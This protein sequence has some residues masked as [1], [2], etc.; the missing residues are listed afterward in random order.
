MKFNAIKPNT[1]TKFGA[2]RRLAGARLFRLGAGAVLL[3]TAAGSQ[4]V[5][6][7]TLRLQ[8]VQGPAG[9]V[10]SEVL[11]QVD[12]SGVKPAGILRI[13]RLDIPAVNQSFVNLVLRCPSMALSNHRISCSAGKL[14]V[15]S[16]W[17][18]DAAIP[19]SFDYRSIE[20]TL[21]LQLPRLVSTYNSENGELASEGLTLALQ[22]NLQQQEQR[23]NFQGELAAEAGQAYADPV[24]LDLT[25]MPIQVQF[26][27]NAEADS[28]RIEL[29][30]FKLQQPGVLAANGTL[31]W[32][33]NA[34]ETA[35]LEIERAQLP[36]AFS[37]YAQPFLIGT[38]FD[39]LTTEGV[40]RANIRRDKQGWSAIGIHG[41]GL[42]LK[43]G[44]DRLTIRG[45]ALD[46]DWQRDIALANAA[47]STLSWQDA[48][49]YKI[50]LGATHW[51]WQMAADDWA[52]TQAVSVPVFDG[53]LEI[54]SA[55]AN[56]L[57]S[58]NPQVDFNA[59]LTPVRLAKLSRAL[60]WPEFR[61]QVS[62]TLP[63]LQYRQGE[64]T[65]AGG[66][67]AK[68]FDGEI[69]LSDLSIANP[70]GARPRLKANATARNLDLEA[71]SSAFAFGRIT[72]RLDADVTGLRMLGWQ[73]V[74][75]KAWLRTPENDRSKH[76]ISQGA[77]DDLASL[78]GGG[79]AGLV[80]R[81]L[82][83]LF[84][85]FAYDRI[86]LGCAMNQGICL[87]RGLGPADNGGYVIVRGR[88]LPRIDV[89]GY[90]RFVSWSALLEQ[91]QSISK[92]P[93]PVINPDK[94]PAR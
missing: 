37:A 40:L 59:R 32:A 49:L 61:G 34:I 46:V 47:V 60:G 52:L 68:A 75:F 2:L 91:L 85:D 21:R 27:G 42:E 74:A 43:D 23:W 14:S 24:F 36:A 84:D 57:V 87:M 94:P 12:I 93:G 48:T 30:Q 28:G 55:A 78:G 90:N 44:K 76:R 3:L 10:A 6:S 1:H 38:A 66:L 18:T 71:M 56:G 26:A 50:E 15:K 79:G 13:A 25:K 92:S 45:G 7:L 11:L 70:L 19:I 62:G 73:P 51:N 4:A 69:E 67:Q 65:L 54:D 80:S 33:Q 16:P 64:L 88:W 77:I 89:V 83:G 8:Q 81:G 20:K 5:Q 82:L 72:G 9:I 58:E 53:R 63:R 41:E 31:V 22:I 39:A 29:S 17:L 35:Q 86:G